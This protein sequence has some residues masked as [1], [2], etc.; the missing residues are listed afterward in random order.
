MAKVVGDVVTGYISCLMSSHAVGYCEKGIYAV[1]RFRANQEAIAVLIDQAH[2][3]NSTPAT[4]PDTGFHW[5]LMLV[6]S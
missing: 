6:G 4:Y 3:A 5:L 1:F 2:P